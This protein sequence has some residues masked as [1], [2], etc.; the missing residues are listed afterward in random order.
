MFEVYKKKITNLRL[1][2]NLEKVLF[3]DYV[4]SLIK[5]RVWA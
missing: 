4:V 2:Q 1:G 5:I 3:L